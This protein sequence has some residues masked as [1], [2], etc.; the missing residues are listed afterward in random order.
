MKDKQAIHVSVE[1]LQS[2]FSW[3]CSIVY[4]C[5]KDSERTSLWQSILQCKSIVH[6]P[7]LLMGDFNNVLHIGERIGSEVT[8]AEIRDFQQCVDSCGLY[9][10][11][12][13]GAYFTWNNKQEE[14]KRVFTRIDRVLANDLWIGSGP[15]GI[16]CFLP[17]GLFDH[18]PCI[19]R[20]WDETNRKPS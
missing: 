15:S 4:G 9:D 7:W 3:T 1:H 5:N 11:V 16:A 17:E 10:L 6:G 13:Q 19:I 2:G 8:L 14:N 20:L 12:T 18:N